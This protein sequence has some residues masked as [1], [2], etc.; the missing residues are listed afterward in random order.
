MN[1]KEKVAAGKIIY[2]LTGKALVKI[3][4]IPATDESICIRSDQKKDIRF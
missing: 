4:C 1:H 2:L 3:S